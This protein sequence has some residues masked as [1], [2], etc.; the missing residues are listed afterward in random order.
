MRFRIPGFRGVTE[1]DTGPPELP[2]WSRV[3]GTQDW[4]GAE[5]RVE[6]EDGKVLVSA[7]NGHGSKI[8]LSLSPASAKSTGEQMT[9]MAARITARELEEQEQEEGDRSE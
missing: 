8:T 2:S 5:A 4:R 6:E 3:A 9:A 1:I 7:S